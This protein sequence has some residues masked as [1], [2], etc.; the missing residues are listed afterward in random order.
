MI[1]QDSGNCT[2]GVERPPVSLPFQAEVI[3]PPLSPRGLHVSRRC[4]KAL[5]DELTLRVDFV[6]TVYRSVLVGSSYCIVIKANSTEGDYFRTAEGNGTCLIECYRM[7]SPMCL[8]LGARQ[9][10]NI[11]ET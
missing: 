2:N 3:G 5:T 1:R 11:G 8:V 4:I 9:K 10:A 7:G 6:Y